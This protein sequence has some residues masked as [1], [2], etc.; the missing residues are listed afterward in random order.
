M[1]ALEDA[2]C[3]KVSLQEVDVSR[4]TRYH[5]L[6]SRGWP[7]V[8]TTDMQSGSGMLERFLHSR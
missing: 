7:G 4:R 8:A 3:I 5:H 6:D 2:R 1:G